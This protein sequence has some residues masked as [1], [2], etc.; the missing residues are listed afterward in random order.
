MFTRK[1]R[2]ED[3]NGL[4]MSDVRRK[5]TTEL[6]LYMLQ[7]LKYNLLKKILDYLLKTVDYHFRIPVLA[8]W[9]C[10]GYIQSEVA[11]TIIIFF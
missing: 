1:M 6:F 8:A 9:H 10:A 4:K 3:K 7:L 2:K 5:N 11:Q